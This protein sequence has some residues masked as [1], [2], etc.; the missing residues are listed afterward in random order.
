MLKIHSHEKTKQMFQHCFIFILYLSI[1]YEAFFII[2]T[3]K[4][5]IYRT[6]FAYI[7]DS[8]YFCNVKRTFCVFKKILKVRVGVDEYIWI[9][10]IRVHSYIY[11]RCYSEDGMLLKWPYTIIEQKWKSQ[12]ALQHQFKQH[13]LML[14]LS[15]DFTLFKSIGYIFL[16]IFFIAVNII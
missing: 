9:L 8:K 12:L 4:R 3:L 5:S 6:L 2:C 15:Y 11:C 14:L 13:F 10:Q 7:Y 16:L 1:I